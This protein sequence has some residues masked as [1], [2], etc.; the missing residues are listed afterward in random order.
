MWYL[1]GEN[2]RKICIDKAEW[3][4][5]RASEED[6]R[7]YARVLRQRSDRKSPADL[8]AA[9]D[10]PRGELI[11]ALWNGHA[12]DETFANLFS[13]GKCKLAAFYAGQRLMNRDEKKA[14]EL[15]EASET[16]L[17]W[18][19]AGCLAA[20]EDE[21]ILLWKRAADGGC[22]RACGHLARHYHEQNQKVQDDG[23]NRISSIS[24]EALIYGAKGYFGPEIEYGSDYFRYELQDERGVF[25]TYE[26]C[27]D[28][29]KFLIGNLFYFHVQDSARLHF[30]GFSFGK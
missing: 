15:F 18:Y 16:A 1:L 29:L 23:T 25:I 20:K 30:L 4:I 14:K 7:Y 28:D 24:R 2:Q 5:K 12:S 6:G 3:W 13:D 10:D 26:E 17:G 11:Y 27:P 9:E 22:F 21:A 19:Y 8:F